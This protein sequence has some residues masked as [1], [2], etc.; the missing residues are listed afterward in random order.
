M[1]QHNA[2]SSN[3]S[4]WKVIVIVTSMFVV[5]LVLLLVY[6]YRSSSNTTNTP[7][8]INEDQSLNNNTNEEEMTTPNPT[9]S[10]PGPTGPGQYACSINGDCK[11]WDLKIEKENCTV[12]FADRSC[13]NKCNDTSIRCKI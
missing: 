4:S 8:P 11:D 7:I 13:E 6:Y 10:Q 9:K 12:T 1:D 3:N 2:T 5:S